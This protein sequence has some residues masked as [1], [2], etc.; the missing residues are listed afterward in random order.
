MPRAW[1]VM[2]ITVTLFA[3]L[4]AAAKERPGAAAV[5]T[6]K[7]GRTIGGELYAVKTNEIIIVDAQ[8][9]D[10]VVAVTDIRRV[11]LR[12]S[13]RRT[14][15]TGAIL[16]FGAGALVGIKAAAADDHGTLGLG[17][18]AAAAGLLG[19]V[20]AVPG[21]L[22]GWAVAAPDREVSIAIER[23]SGEPLRKA[24]SKMR[25]LARVPSLR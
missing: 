23:L 21:A 8:G 19:L 16:G 2:L 20:G 10:E 6:L 12:K 14:V 13:I 5:V 1:P 25:K 17:G 9:A 3:G 7:D 24:L 18:Y 11:E 22:A 4:D 15:K